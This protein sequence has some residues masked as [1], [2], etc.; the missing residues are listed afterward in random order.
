MPVPAALLAAGRALAPAAKQA[1]KMMVANA[2]LGGGNKGNSALSKS[3]S[4]GGQQP[5]NTS[6]GQLPE[7]QKNIPFGI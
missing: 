4:S 3:Q 7:G 6:I 1:G 2:V 5:T